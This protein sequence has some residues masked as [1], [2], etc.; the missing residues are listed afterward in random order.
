MS[1]QDIVDVSGT[2]RWKYIHHIITD[3][4]FLSRYIKY[5][6]HFHTANCLTAPEL[7]QLASD[8]GQEL[9]AKI[10]ALHSRSQCYHPATFSKRRLVARAQTK[11]KVDHP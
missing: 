5:N 9:L 3:A 4:D 6:K 11:V 2:E 8:S 7:G 10:A 1:I